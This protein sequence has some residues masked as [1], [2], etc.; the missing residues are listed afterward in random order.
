MKLINVDAFVKSINESI[1]EAHKWWSNAQTDEIRIRAEQA[2]A[3]F[4]EASLRA[5]QMPEVDA[6]PVVRC[7]ECRFG[8]EICGNIECSV[9]INVPSEYHGYNWFCPNGEQK[10]EKDGDIDG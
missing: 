2:I 6:I 5:R 4:C 7:A 1:A 9:D 8:R 10:D 3:T